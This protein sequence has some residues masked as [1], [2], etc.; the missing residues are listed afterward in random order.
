MMNIL[1]AIAAG[2]ASALMFASIISGALFSLVLVYLS[3]LPLMVAALGWGPASAL[4]GGLVAGVVLALS[5]NFMHGLGFVLTVATPAFWLGHLSLLAQ[6]AT[7]SSTPGGQH[8]AALEWYPIGRVVLWAAL[9]AALIMIFALLT[10]GSSGDDITARLREQALQALSTIN[11]AGLEVEDK[12]RIATFIARA[13]PL[14]AVGTT[15]LMYLLNLWLAGRITRTSHRLR[16]PWP[17]LHGIELPQTAI[18]VLA[19]AL[20]LSF[21][22]G[23]PGLIAQI[24]GAAL[25]TAY[26]LVGLAVLHA[27]TRPS[28][29]RIWWRLAAYGVIVMFI[30]PLLLV[31]MLGLLDAS[32]GLRRR[33]SNRAKPP[34][35]SP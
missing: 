32:F 23:L 7:P 18:V 20:L 9:I 11:R 3:P 13:L 4:L 25:L 2:C 10:T 33:F 22:G 16:R 27:L 31:P 30:W 5:F 17:D 6:P 34:T 35:P 14:V 21:A 15:I 24:V 29:G 12:E 28:S 8:D 26:T 1:I 19:A